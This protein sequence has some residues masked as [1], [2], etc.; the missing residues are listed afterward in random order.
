MPNTQP[1]AKPPLD[2]GEWLRERA[3]YR[4]SE[5]EANLEAIIENADALIWSVDRDMNL[6]VCNQAFSLAVQRLIGDKPGLG[7]RLT[8]PFPARM[9]EKFEDWISSALSGQIRRVV[10]HDFDPAKKAWYDQTITP[11]RRKGE[12]I[13]AACIATDITAHKLAEAQIL[14]LNASLETKIAGRTAELKEAKE[15]AQAAN[16]A[17]SAFLINMSHETRTPMT[18]IIGIAALLKQTAL[19]HD[20]RE[21][22]HTLSDSADA[23]L[24]LLNDMLDLSKVESGRLT[25]EETSFDL[26]QEVDSVIRLMAAH[27]VQKHLDIHTQ[28]DPNIPAHLMGDPFRIRQILSGMVSNALKFTG[29]GAIDIEARA[30]AG[31]APKRFQLHLTVSDTGIGIP[32]D[33]LETIFHPFSQADALATRRSGSTGLGLSICASLAEMMGGRAWAENRP[34]GGSTFHVTMDLGVSASAPPVKTADAAPAT[35]S[36]PRRVLLAEDNLVNQKVT[37]ALLLKRGHEVVIASNGKE[38]LKQLE[39]SDFDLVLMDV[40]MPEMDGLET[41]R[42]WRAR[43]AELLAE[44][45]AKKS[46]PSP[47]RRIVALTASA[48]RG[49]QE[50][51][52]AAGMDGYLNKPFQAADLYA[53]VESAPALGLVTPTAVLANGN[54][55]TTCAMPPCTSAA[56]SAQNQAP[57]PPPA[58]LDA[59]K[60]A[61]GGATDILKETAKLYL[62]EHTRALVA[63]QSAIL[64]SDAAELCLAAHGYKNTIAPFQAALA[65]DIILGLERMGRAGSFTAATSEYAKLSA[66]DARLAAQLSAWLSAA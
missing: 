39:Q 19:T 54:N 4:R 48:M 29:T 25:L 23:L 32:P 37:A 59:A 55:A 45:S 43:E 36:V 28:I 20:Q 51:C 44:S 46:E 24:H 64:R 42:R 50:V 17:K 7:Q 6:I 18:G 31:K 60:Q 53:I 16:Q 11:I 41:T 56:Q 61:L 22:L 13:G 47:R 12:I 26:R 63:V 49:D 9:A 35:P 10:V 5:A 27:A 30:E 33:Q 15:Q 57:P 38:A 3:E 1:P 21:L 40:Q 58:D 14:E 66:E 8:G 34:G 2:A 65:T 52:M 62:Q